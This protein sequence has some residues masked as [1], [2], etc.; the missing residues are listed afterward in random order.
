MNPGSLQSFHR[1]RRLAI[2][3]AVLAPLLALAGVWWLVDRVVLAPPRPRHDSPAAACV[4]FLVDARGLPRLSAADA[5][6]CV[7]EQLR[8]AAQDATFREAFLT[9]LRR[10]TSDEQDLFVRHLI[11]A[12]KPMVMRDVDAF[13]ATPP[14]GRDAF[15]D[16]RI[17]AYNRLRASFGDVHISKSMLAGALPTSP[18]DLLQLLSE[19]TSADERN[20]ATAYLT[21]LAGRIAAILADDALRAAIEQRIAAPD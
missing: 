17:V 11:G 14:A 15:L 5:E 21:A 4:R 18:T 10:S 3:A 7:L 8:R 20:R 13:G 12:F 1:Y 16:D 9:A 6:R 2:A 19:S